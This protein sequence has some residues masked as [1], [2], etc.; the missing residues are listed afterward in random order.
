MFTYFGVIFLRKFNS[1]YVVNPIGFIELMI[2]LDVICGVSLI[3][4]VMK[5]LIL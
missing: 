3:V 5:L 4:G 2:F 1:G